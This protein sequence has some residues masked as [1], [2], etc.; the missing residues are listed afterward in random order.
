[1]HSVWELALVAGLL[2]IL[3]HFLA[4]ASARV[5]YLTAT[6]ALAL[7]FALPIVTFRAIGDNY[8]WP[9]SPVVR[10][11]APIKAES[12]FSP[13]NPISQSRVTAQ[14]APPV[15]VRLD[16]RFGERWRTRMASW[17]AE[18]APWLIPIWGLGVFIFS[19]LNLGGW[20]ATQRLRLLGVRPIASELV[21]RTAEL[22]AR[23]GLTR[24]VRL[25]ESTLVQVPI[26]IGF[27]S[28]LV[29][30]P[31]SVLAGLPSDHLEAILA[32]EL[33]HIRRH[34][35]LVNLLQVL[36]ETLL[37]YHPAA[38]W[39]SRKIRIERENCCDDIAA[40]ICGRR[41]YAEALISVEELR[42]PGGLLAVAATGGG[43]MLAR[44]QRLVGRPSHH[45][46]NAPLA[47]VLFLMGLL[48]VPLATTYSATNPGTAGPAA[49]T[50]PDAE[51]A[52]NIGFVPFTPQW[53]RF[54]RG[55]SIVI[56]SVTG[57]RA[58]LEL[59]GTYLVQ[60]TYTLASM[61][62]AGLSIS[63]THSE[64]T[65]PRVL[66]PTYP[67][68][69]TKVQMGSGRFSLR[70]T[71]RYAG[72]FHV[73]FNPPAGGESRGTVYFSEITPPT[74]EASSAKAAEPSD[75]TPEA[76][77]SQAADH[78][79]AVFEKAFPYD[80]GFEDY[81]KPWSRFNSGDLITIRAIRGNRQQIEVGGS[82]AVL[83][84]Y[85]LSSMDEA[86]LGL[87]VTEEVAPGAQT[88]RTRVLP[89]Q[90]KK[91][92][93][94]TGTFVL[95]FTMM[96]DGAPHVSLYPTAPKS[97]QQG[98]VY[99]EQ[100]SPRLS[101]AEGHDPGIGRP[102]F[103]HYLEKN[104][105]VEIG[106][107]IFK[108]FLG[109]ESDTVS[110]IERSPQTAAPAETKSAPTIEISIGENQ[111]LSVN[112]KDIADEELE[113]MLV[114]AHNVDLGTSVT[115]MDHE[116]YKRAKLKL[117]MDACLKAGLAKIVLRQSTVVVGIDKD[118]VISINNW[119]VTDD[120][121]E[122]MLLQAHSSNPDISVV[123]DADEATQAARLGYVMNCCRK[124]GLSRFS[125][126]I[127]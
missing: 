85:T 27:L 34:D 87:F 109:D 65:E 92:E 83:G 66:S 107:P 127:R 24:P 13:Q 63:V 17:L 126:Q 45:Q 38:W 96:A 53:G 99:F 51:F 79:A 26:V 3:L 112:G 28:P 14:T 113:P 46:T 60:G 18:G 48:L 81:Q 9:H 4:N 73:S 64:I 111:M 21:R 42:P 2:A 23:V 11:P 70:M 10:L 16:G 100:T 1:M 19:I 86:M 119:H 56:T 43:N 108:N 74:S 31:A 49:A 98:G 8:G 15:A 44:I 75:T 80:I 82:Y 116:V 39:V 125:M 50:P 90:H 102:I 20:V 122:P 33:A 124:A 115:V 117:V 76:L 52:Y 54:S 30:I 105:H 58:H 59:G 35:Y 7:M 29:L 91:L 118:G 71:M 25:V 32:H 94:G 93:K 104:A 121:V 55:D 97:E 47:A 57:N 106:D 110:K 37:F 103:K 69:K 89:G 101:I 5:R 88:H 120:N 114:E 41:V 123:I 72:T 95:W 78:T 36:A 68:Q 22:S 62:T 77:P 40:G 67:E 6:A 61:P 12:S 84:T